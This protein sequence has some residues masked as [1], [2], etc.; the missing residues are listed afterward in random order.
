MGFSCPRVPSNAAFLI[1][2]LISIKSLSCWDLSVSTALGALV[3]AALGGLVS[4]ALG[5]VV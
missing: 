3:S 5:V 4:A 1:L 2:E